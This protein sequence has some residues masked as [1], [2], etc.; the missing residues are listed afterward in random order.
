MKVHVLVVEDEPVLYE[1]LR[2]ALLKQRFTVDEYTKSYDEA[3]V[4]IKENTPDVVLL[5]ID[6]HGKKDGIDL[7]KILFSVYNIPFI[8]VTDLDDDMTFSKGLHTNHEQF[9][10]KTKPSLNINEVIRGIYTVLHKNNASLLRYQKD[11]VIGLVSYLDEVNDFG[12]S[13]VTRVPV[14]YKDIAFFTVKPFVNEDD[15]EEAIRTNYLWFYTK[16]KEYFFLKS[17]LKEVLKHLPLN[18]VRI[19][20]SYIVNISPEM[21]DGRINGSRI[22]VLGKEFKIKRTYARSFDKRLQSYYHS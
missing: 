21:L 3:I 18:F 15:E 7:G 20:E 13:G 14:A 19:N 6:L 9:I 8:Y 2:K 17:S 5:D 11:A 12:N 22:S 10:V 16:R 1:R 4:R